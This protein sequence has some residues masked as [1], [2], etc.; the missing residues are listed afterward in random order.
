MSNIF[1][2]AILSNATQIMVFHNHPS[3]DPTPSEVDK[4]VTRN[5]GRAGGLMNI[6]IVDHIIVGATGSYYSF[7]ENNWR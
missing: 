5:I 3:G 4:E 1:K 7:S 6:A 2:T